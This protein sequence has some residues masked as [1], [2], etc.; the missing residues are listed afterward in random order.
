MFEHAF[1]PPSFQ[2]PAASSPRR[3]V[4]RLFSV[5]LAVMMMVGSGLLNGTAPLP[6]PT[7][8]AQDPLPAPT[9][10]SPP[11]GTTTTVSNY[12][13]LGIP[14]LRWAPVPGATAYRIQCS[15][16]IAFTNIRLEL[17]TANTRY[18]PADAGVFSDGAWYW[19]VRVESPSPPSDYS[20]IGSFTKQWASPTNKPVLT[21]PANGATLAFYDAPDFSWQP[22]TGA[23]FYR[24]QIA[25]SPD[26]FSSP[27]YN[28]GTLAPTHQPAL[29]R[30]NG[31]YYW[32]VVPVSPAN[33][34]G[35]PSEV[36]AFTLSY[37]QVPTLLTP[38]NGSNPVFTPSFRWTAVRGAQFYRL[39]YTTDPS[40]SAQVT[41]VD[42]RNT[43]YT[44]IDPLRNDV[45][46]YWRVQAWSGQSNSDWGGP[47][48][49]VKKWYTQTVLLTPVNNY[50]YVE[51]PLFSWTPV[52]GASI[53]KLEVSPENTFPPVG[54]GFT[55]WTANPFYVYPD[56]DWSFRTT[57]YWRVTPM[58]SSNS[59]EGVPSVVSSFAY[60][61]TAGAP[62]LIHPPYFYS[63]QDPNLGYLETLQPH[64]ERAVA[65][66][67]LMW[68]RLLTSTLVPNE[69]VAAYR[70][71][72]DDDPLFDSPNWTFDTENL[73]AVPTADA[74]FTPVAGRDY[75]WRVR[76]LDG[77]GG[78]EIGQWSQRWRARFDASLGLSPLPT[79]TL[80]RPIHGAE[81]ASRP[82]R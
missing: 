5:G 30:A 27:L 1:I 13:P 75:Y 16:D 45:N 37:S 38:A 14:E 15:Q 18:T 54:G 6:V 81:W 4:R 43:T 55:A 53:Y 40:F 82:S 22:V 60:R 39:Q 10:L 33:R 66:P 61:P 34:D 42:T 73:S 47:W 26:G 41:Q 9:L 57:W 68:H 2:R 7:V 12:P 35:T 11:D 23:A 77:L 50:Q 49:F 31:V 79:A 58:D 70:I 32:R 25:A 20:A 21:A 56:Q 3:A 52:P 46:Y 17:V 62:Q 44:P 78:S 69:Q 72:V 28:Q 24:F 80:L 71:Q 51:H 59:Q 67:I 8:H 76:P 65:W 29:K 64:E 19:R 63:P 74:P 48:T 36:R